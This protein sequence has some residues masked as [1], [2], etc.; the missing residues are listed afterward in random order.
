MEALVQELLDESPTWSEQESRVIGGFGALLNR[1]APILKHPKFQEE[2]EWRLISRPLF[3]SHDRFD[4]RAGASMLVPYYRL[5]LTDDETQFTVNELVVGPTIYREQ[6]RRA[7]ISLMYK[8][9]FEDPDMPV[10]SSSVPF[11]N[12]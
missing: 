12:G 11:R 7:A 3:S 9:G 4:V 6:A 5:S 10:R 2:R 1:Y 8:S